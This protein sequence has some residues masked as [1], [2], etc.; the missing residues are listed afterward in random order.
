MAWFAAQRRARHADR[1][2]RRNEGRRLPPASARPLPRGFGA[3]VLGRGAA[4][5]RGHGAPGL[6]S[7][8]SAPSTHTKRS[9]RTLPRC[10]LLRVT[11][12]SV[13]K[14]K[15]EKLF[16]KCSALP[17][18][19]M[20]NSGPRQPRPAPGRVTTGRE[21]ADR[22][23]PGGGPTAPTGSLLFSHASTCGGNFCRAPHAPSLGPTE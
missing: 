11:C 22:E 2:G 17:N 4:A 12:A 1:T 23:D 15:E 14:S 13:L 9:R 19:E 3:A 16:L 10:P 6:G 21:D 8:G 5:V 20:W 7:A 18:L